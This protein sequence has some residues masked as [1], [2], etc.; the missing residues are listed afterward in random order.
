MKSTSMSSKAKS[1]ASSSAFSEANTFG[2][3]RQ[4]K[5]R[6]L[7]EIDILTIND[8][9]FKSTLTEKAI[10]N[11]IYRGVYKLPKDKIH[12]IRSAWK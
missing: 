11:E 4:G 6:D 9:P 3:T 5:M 12:G 8:Q 10:Y 2:G 1:R 7:I